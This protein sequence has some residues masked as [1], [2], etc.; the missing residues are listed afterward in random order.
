MS[1]KSDL[2]SILSSVRSS[3]VV[4]GGRALVSCGRYLQVF[5]AASHQH[6]TLYTKQCSA[7]N[8]PLDFS[9][10]IFK[11]FSDGGTQ[12][13]AYVCVPQPFPMA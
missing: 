3:G 8:S 2:G 13:F 4:L 9:P 1:L 12:A 11:S 5:K 10:I 6:Y 7:M